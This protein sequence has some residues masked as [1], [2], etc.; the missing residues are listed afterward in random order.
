MHYGNNINIFK[1]IFKMED[2]KIQIIQIYKDNPCLWD[3]SKSEYHDRNKRNII[4]GKI[5]KELNVKG[6]N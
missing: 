6:N 2:N 4:F 5:A 3:C 1:Q